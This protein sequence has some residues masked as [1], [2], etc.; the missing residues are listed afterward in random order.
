MQ[1]ASRLGN[2]TAFVVVVVV[3]VLLRQLGPVR[4]ES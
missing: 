2:N 1:N 3:V 4:V